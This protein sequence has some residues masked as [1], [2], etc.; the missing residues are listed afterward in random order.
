MMYNGVQE[1]KARQ[2]RLMEQ[3]RE[4]EQALSQAGWAE[5]ASRFIE[6]SGPSRA[7]AFRFALDDQSTAAARLEAMVA[8][9][10]RV[11]ALPYGTSS[12]FVVSGAIA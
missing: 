6:K 11:M 7:A 5:E 3:A 10:C 4:N 8:W 1:T 12:S 9:R 2:E